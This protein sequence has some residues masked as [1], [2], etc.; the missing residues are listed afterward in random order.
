MLRFATDNRQ[1]DDNQS[2]VIKT[3]KMEI[4]EVLMDM[5]EDLHDDIVRLKFSPFNVQVDGE[6]V[7]KAMGLLTRSLKIRKDG[8]LEH[9][10]V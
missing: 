3:E 1:D 9:L 10:I 2:E 4:T 7:S 5:L 8:K 6:L